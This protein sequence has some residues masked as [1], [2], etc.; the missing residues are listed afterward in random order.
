MI[1]TDAIVATVTPCSTFD[2]SPAGFRDRDVEDLA[3]LAAS[4]DGLALHLSQPSADEPGQN[5]PAD[6][7]AMK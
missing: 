5:S 3:R 1:D 4:L 2:R 7:V 6:P